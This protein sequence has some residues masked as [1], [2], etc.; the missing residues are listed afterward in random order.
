MAV[1]KRI[2]P[3]LAACKE[4]MALDLKDKK[5]AKNKKTK[6]ISEKKTTLEKEATYF[7]QQQFQGPLG[8]GL[9]VFQPEPQK[10]GNRCVSFCI[11]CCSIL[12]ILVNTVDFFYFAAIRVS[13]PTGSSKTSVRR[14]RF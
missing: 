10:G 6:L 14:P 9:R 13:A 1:A 3:E 8:K 5:I 2:Q 4:Q 12:H 7:F 11:F